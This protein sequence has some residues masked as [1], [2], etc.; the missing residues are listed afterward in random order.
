MDLQSAKCE[1]RDPAR[2]G[3]G[4][5]LLEWALIAGLL[6]GLVQLISG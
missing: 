6:V 1:L 5:L 4:L 2:V 3:F